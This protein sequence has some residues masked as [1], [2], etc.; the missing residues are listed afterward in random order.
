TDP[1]VLE[2]YKDAEAFHK[3]LHEFFYRENENGG[4]SKPIGMRV[5]T[6]GDGDDGGQWNCQPTYD[7]KA[8]AKISDALVCQKGW[9]FATLLERVEMACA[10]RQEGWA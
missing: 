2:A 9:E 5:D 3:C 10:I 1:L 4:E 8:K 7:K 6:D